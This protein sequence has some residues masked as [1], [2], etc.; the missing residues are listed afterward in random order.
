MRAAASD[1]ATYLDYLADDAVLLAILAS[2]CLL[3]IGFLAQLRYLRRNLSLVS[4]TLNK[5]EE[6]SRLMGEKLP[7][8]VFFQLVYDDDS[9]FRFRSLTGGCSEILGIGPGKLLK[10]ARLAYDHLHGEDAVELKK[11]YRHSA[12]LMEP[13]HVDLRFL[14]MDGRL[15]WLRVSAVPHREGESLLWDGVLHDITD[16]KQT[17]EALTEEKLNF[18]NLFDTIDDFVLV[19][20]L[21]GRLLHTN[22]AAE[23][24]LEYSGDALRGM[25]LIDLYDDLHR[26]E[27]RQ[28]LSLMQSEKSL[29]CGLPFHTRSGR[30]V[31]VEMTLFQG[32]W[33]GTRAVFCVARD[34]TLR[35][36]T[37]N[38]LRESQQMLRLIINTIPLSVFWKN[39][40]SEYLGC[41]ASFLET[42]GFSDAEEVI[43]KTPYDLFDLEAADGF[44]EL[45]RKVVENN[46]PLFNVILPYKRS[47]GTTGQREISKMPLQNAEGRAVGILEI[48]RDVTEQN[49]ASDQ[50][51]QSLIDLERF[52]QLMRGR[53]R[54][55]LEL[56]SEINRLLV[57]LGREE[58]YQTTADRI[59]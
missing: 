51:R 44:V 52:N 34:T 10:D 57:E 54:R 23:Q 15:K 26:P 40:E 28:L 12:D 25:R 24:H 55:T 47:N 35:L 2:N 38:A 7:G 36:Q 33:R 1:A 29:R 39:R 3:L 14:D 4:T 42:C 50:L 6:Y 49:E 43:G 9:G 27:I 45:D 41:N 13:V 16:C 59:T 48:W 18:R 58:K 31:P 11:A 37:E 21:Q 5:T 22:P 8:T 17:E 53:E 20:D 56:K 19:C 32:A 46:Q 30:A